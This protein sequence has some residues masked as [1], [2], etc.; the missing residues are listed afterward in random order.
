MAGHLPGELPGEPSLKAKRLRVLETY[1]AEAD[2]RNEF[3]SSFATM[4]YRL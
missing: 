1:F 4:E 2:L 3:T